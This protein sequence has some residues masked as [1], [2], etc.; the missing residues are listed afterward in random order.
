MQTPAPGCDDGSFISQIAARGGIAVCIDV[1][2]I[3]LG[4]T[5]RGGFDANDCA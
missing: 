3:L 4:F 2:V 5:I 1:T